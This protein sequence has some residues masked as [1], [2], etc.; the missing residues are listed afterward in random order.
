MNKIKKERLSRR[1]MPHL[2]KRGSFVTLFQWEINSAVWGR[3]IRKCWTHH[4]DSV[5]LCTLKP[6]VC[7]HKEVR[8]GE[9]IKAA[10]GKGR[11]YSQMTLCRNAKPLRFKTWLRLGTAFIYILKIRTQKVAL[12]RGGRKKMFLH[13]PRCV[14]MATSQTATLG[15]C[16]V[17]F[18][19]LAFCFVFLPGWQYL[20]KLSLSYVYD[21]TLLSHTPDFVYM[22]IV[23]LRCHIHMPGKKTVAAFCV[24]SA[25][26]RISLNFSREFI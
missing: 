5:H 7:R 22:H 9:P 18:V 10:G 14:T 4:N 11:R 16:V 8:A 24:F 6:S 13:L 23:S 26:S 3:A 1:L 2:A 17:S 19:G 21:Y 20:L 25:H 12:K 15:R